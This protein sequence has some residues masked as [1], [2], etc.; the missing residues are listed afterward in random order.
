MS[1][2]VPNVRFVSDMFIAFVRNNKVDPAQVEAILRAIIRGLSA[3]GATALKPQLRPENKLLPE[4][5]PEPIHLVEVSSDARRCGIMHL[6]DHTCR[7]PIGDPGSETFYFCGSTP[8]EKGPY[9]EYHA[10]MSVVKA[11][12]SRRRKPAEAIF[13]CGA[14]LPEMFAGRRPVK[15]PQPMNGQPGIDSA[16]KEP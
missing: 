8:C 6:T 3:S 5:E 16:L 4:M 9:C 14:R 11:R 2:E 10:R 1:N 15:S 7:W 12:G 13:L